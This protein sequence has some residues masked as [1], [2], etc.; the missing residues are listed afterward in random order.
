MK[1]HNKNII[2]SFIIILFVLMLCLP[3][4]IDLIPSSEVK[5]VVTVIFSLLVFLFLIYIT[6]D[7]IKKR[8]YT[9]TVYIIFLDIIGIVVY[10]VLFYNCFNKID[11]TDIEALLR[12]NHIQVA[13]LLYILCESIAL[14]FLKSNRFKKK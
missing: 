14:S 9:T 8:E 6:Y 10:A 2:V 3:K 11:V 7:D 13:C 1:I 12:S 5:Y 4:I